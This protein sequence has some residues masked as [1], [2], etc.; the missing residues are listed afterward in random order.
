MKS[1]IL[2]I[3]RIGTPQGFVL[4]PINYYISLCGE[5]PQVTFN[6]DCQQELFDKM[7]NDL[8]YHD[9]DP[10]SS[11]AAISFFQELTT[12]AFED[13]EYVNLD[14]LETEALHL[15]LVVSPLELIQI[16]FEFAIFPND[17]SKIPL[18]ANN[19]RIIT[20]TREVRQE[21]ESSYKWPSKP[22]ILFA[23]SE[24]DPEK[25]P[26]PHREHLQT[27]VEIVEELA[28]P[29]GEN[30]YPKPNI[31]NFLTELPNA[32]PESITKEIEDAIKN[33][34]PFTHIHIL[35][36]GGQKIVYG[37]NRDFR[38][39]MCKNG[40]PN[41]SS[42]IDGE[43]LSSVLIPF[44]R[45]TAPAVVSLAVCD[46]ANT[47]TILSTGSLSYQ[48]HN[49]GIPCVFA[50]QFPLT[51]R[52][53]V[54][55]V[56]NL[57]RRLIQG[58]DP[59][60]ALYHTRME[61]KKE[62]NHDWASLVAYA[63]FPGDIN[64]QLL[65]TK[66]QLIFNTMKTTNAWVDHSFKHW[67]NIEI[68][69][70][71]S[72]LKEL[73]SRLEKSITELSSHFDEDENKSSLETNA[74][75][76]EHLGLLGSAYKRKAEFNFKSIALNPDK[77]SS[78]TAASG[79]D[80]E[81]AKKFYE[82]GLFADQGNHWNAVQ[83]LSLKA[84]SEG[85][86]VDELRLWYATEYM[87]LMNEKKVQKLGDKAWAWGTLSELYLLQPLTVH[88]PE[89]SKEIKTS[90][91]MAKDYL[92]K[93][94]SLPDEYNYVKES[95]IRQFERY[96]NWWPSLFKTVF[97]DWLKEHAGEIRKVLP[98]LEELTG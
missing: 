34:K 35:A 32:S 31:S 70:K 83:F 73:E 84:I 46:S 42:K 82:L 2:G 17:P 95:T 44:D 14:P 16:P 63:R 64:L 79:T 5:K 80:I 26:V 4:N 55:M 88:K 87:A 7:I 28:K 9:G 49:A 48:L 78:Y 33:Q 25:M 76:S 57:Y 38:L 13:F 66:L 89:A 41:K 75:Q 94:A 53:S 11:S 27:L 3:A 18:L 96:L 43:K 54:I 62:Q 85:T 86:L 50:S 56:K 24:P 90:I 67:T 74:L 60:L 81:Q 52:G 39:I 68:K 15:R 19:N 91:S 23:W 30:S 36:H 12:K 77:E 92:A 6:V 22:K 40:L 72:L 93:I 61:L 10:S 21:S 58:V 98:R 8:R 45:K 51:K 47:N 71:H 59:R 29:I 37:D 65:D 1:Q 97:P 69:D 20:L